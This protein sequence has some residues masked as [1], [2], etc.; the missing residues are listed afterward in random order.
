MSPPQN[1]SIPPYG[2]Y[3]SMQ[4]CP[5]CRSTPPHNTNTLDTFLHSKTCQKSFGLLFSCTEHHC[6]LCCLTKLLQVTQTA[7]GGS[8]YQMRSPGRISYKRLG[9]GTCFRVFIIRPAQRGVGSFSFGTP[10]CV[11]PLCL[12]V[13]L[14]T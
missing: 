4:P 1:C 3:G 2:W 5:D 13:R 7:K 14:S 9:L 12:C 11:V 10:H 8:N 6:G